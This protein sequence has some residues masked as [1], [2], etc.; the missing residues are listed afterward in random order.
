MTP[1]AFAVVGAM[2]VRVHAVAFLH[3]TCGVCLPEPESPRPADM[4]L[5]DEPLYTE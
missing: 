3:A 1:P 4:R 2:S 5:A